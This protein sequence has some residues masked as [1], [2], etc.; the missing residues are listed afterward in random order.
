MKFQGLK[1]TTTRVSST[2]STLP[3]HRIG[4][5]AW[6]LLNYLVIRFNRQSDTKWIQ[7][8]CSYD[9]GI[10]GSSAANQLWSGATPS[11]NTGS[12][13]DGNYLERDILNDY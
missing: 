11:E 5:H 6:L 13:P 3:L 12:E 1:S 2:W 8:D 7:K 9:M 10:L 4:G